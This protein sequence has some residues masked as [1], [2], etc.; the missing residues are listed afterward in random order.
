MA[1]RTL[2]PVI[3]ADPRLFGRRIPG[4]IL[5]GEPLRWSAS[6]DLKLFANAFAVGFLFVSVLIF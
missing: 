1:M 4:F 2:R 3:A 5:D 6:D